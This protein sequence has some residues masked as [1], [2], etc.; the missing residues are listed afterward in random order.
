MESME[1]VEVRPFGCSSTISGVA[2]GRVASGTGEVAESEGVLKIT[3]TGTA[4][5]A[6]SDSGL[7]IQRAERDARRDDVKR[8]RESEENV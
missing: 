3:G 2:T 1:I 5:A 6:E 4:E 8:A 7:D